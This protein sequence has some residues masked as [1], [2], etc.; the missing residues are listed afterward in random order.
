MP[1]WAGAA[2]GRLMVQ[3]CHQCERYVFPPELA[4]TGCLSR[5][6]RWEQSSGRG[7]IHSFS[8]VWRPPVPAFETPY[9]VAV[10]ELEE[11][12]HMLTNIVECPAEQLRC[13]MAVAVQF[14]PLTDDIGLPVFRPDPSP[15]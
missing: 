7:T 6:L 5:D 1:H 9:V 2:Q 3:H 4:C 8:E 15:A 11:G 13:D 10:V 12:W 14:V